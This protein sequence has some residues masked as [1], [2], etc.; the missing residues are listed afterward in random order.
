M[1]LK[2]VSDIMTEAP[3]DTIEQGLS[4]Q[5]AANIM[6]ERNRGSLIVLDS[7][8]PVGIITERDIV[9]RLVADA[10]DP[11]EVKVK[12]IMSTPLI[13]IGPEA[14]IEAAA[15][16]MYENKIRR[17]P[18]VENDNLVGIVT[19]TD[20]AKAMLRDKRD[21]MLMAM[22]RFKYLEELAKT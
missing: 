14:T 9:R 8:K 13:T 12:D 17:L 16:V 7:N 10:R 5:Y 6:R 21:G 20:F 15:K 11:Q 19:T 4:V 1:N 22:A 3:L 18:V 2:R